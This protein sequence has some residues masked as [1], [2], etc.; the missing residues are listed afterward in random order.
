MPP[1]RFR[2][3]PALD[4]RRR[5]EERANLAVLEARRVSEA[6]EAAQRAA[7]RQFDEAMA[8]ALTAETE[9]GDVTVAIWYRNWMRTQRR[10]LARCEAIAE[11]RRMQLREAERRLVEARRNVRVL[12]RLKDRARAEQDRRDREAEQK[13]L[14]EL[15]VLQFALRQRG[16]S[17]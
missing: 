8:R 11:D 17:S 5:Q 13:A 6:A 2:P 12:E 1:F 9:G 3:Q 7:Q 4:L 15:A 14:D 16:E 10:E